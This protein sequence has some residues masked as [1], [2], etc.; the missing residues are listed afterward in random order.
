MCVTKFS[1]HIFM[2]Q[3]GKSNTSAHYPGEPHRRHQYLKTL[4]HSI[5]NSYRSTLLLAGITLVWLYICGDEC[6]NIITKCWMLFQ[7]TINVAISSKP[8]QIP[9]YSYLKNYPINN[10]I[11]RTTR[12]SHHSWLWNIH[13]IITTGNSK[14]F[15]WNLFILF[16]ADHIQSHY[17]LPGMIITFG[18]IPHRFNLNLP[19]RRGRPFTTQR[20]S[21][22]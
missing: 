5:Q 10:L 15:L 1:I 17:L 6:V 12:K 9:I 16:Y 3:F 4:K 2:H 20:T 22:K 13:H 11:L 21:S 8:Y 14:A 7:V 18:L 19:V